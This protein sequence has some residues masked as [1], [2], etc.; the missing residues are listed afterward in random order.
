MRPF[1]IGAQTPVAAVQLATSS[2]PIVP[3]TVSRE[4]YTCFHVTN[5]GQTE[6][7]FIVS[8]AS[9]GKNYGAT[10]HNY[11]TEMMRW[12]DYRRAKNIND[13]T[14][15]M[16]DTFD[17]NC[18]GS[19]I[20]GV[21]FI[22]HRILVKETDYT[23][24]S[25]VCFDHL[26]DLPKQDFSTEMMRWEYTK[27][28]KNINDGTPSLIQ[29]FFTPKSS[30]SSKEE[31]LSAGARESIVGGSSGGVINGKFVGCNMIIEASN[32]GE[33]QDYTY[34]VVVCKQEAWGNMTQNFS[35]EMMRWDD[36]RRAKNINDGTPMMKDTFDK[37]SVNGA[38]G[39]GPQQGFGLL[40]QP[41]PTPAV[42]QGFGQ[43]QSTGFGQR[44]GG[45]GS[46]FR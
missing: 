40:Q 45:F 12:D 28:E 14:P 2:P 44:P 11:C 27:K 34:M 15:S 24:K 6:E 42:L 22:Q 1:G 19:L 33:R 26:Y 39:Q 23:F 21:H 5:Q 3:S 25:I 43:Q 18:M 29:T 46:G 8:L 9:H 37:P 41:S 38:F 32:T 20:D 31:P 30:S 16:K 7:Y 10:E 17:K 13:G 36:Y 4:G 35:T